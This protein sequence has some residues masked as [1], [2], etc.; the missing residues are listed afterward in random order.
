MARKTKSKPKKTERQRDPERG[1]AIRRMAV[2]VLIS[3][4]LIGGLA[5]GYV[6]L[7]REVR[8][9][10]VFTHEP[11]QVVLVNRPMWMGDFLAATIT[12]RIR[13]K[14][15]SSAIDHQV[16]VNCA[17]LA[18]SDPWVRQ[19]RRVRRVYGQGPGD[20][21]EVDCEFRAPVALVKYLEHYVL[22]DNDRIVLPELFGEEDVS[23]I[24][25]GQ[26][27]RMNIRVIDGVTRRPPDAGVR[28][29]GDDLQAGLWMAKMLH[30]KPYANE[31]DR[32]DVSNYA[33]RR[34]ANEAHIV[35]HTRHGTEVRWGQPHDWRGF[36]APVEKKLAN[37][38]YVYER[39]G[40]VDA[41]Q[42]WIDLRYDRV[43]RPEDGA[44]N[45]ATAF[46]H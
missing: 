30:D 39:Y 40:R 41:N 35:L 42:P 16:V 2:K 34:N 25:Y 14:A 7:H 3:I 37:L 43:L 38:R 27:G 36:E 46:G 21:I 32:I 45:A 20:T 22:V 6:Y 26:D 24:V 4:L 17:L 33:G 9:R 18:E 23:R 28:W 8:T 31:I 1:R 5:A 11:P 10:I 44:A 13:P 12:E 29:A 15:G 19:V